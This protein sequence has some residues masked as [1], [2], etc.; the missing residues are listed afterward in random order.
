MRSMMIA[1][2]PR[3][4]FETYLYYSELLP[5]AEL[6]FHGASGLIQTD[7]RHQH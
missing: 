5:G 4:A 1:F 6:Y 2:R 3:D 7:G